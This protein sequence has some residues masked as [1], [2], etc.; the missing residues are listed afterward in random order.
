LPSL[1]ARQIHPKY[2]VPVN[3]IYVTALFSFLLSLIYIGSETAFYAIT[4]LFTVALLQCYMFSIGSIL[5]RRIR[6]P[7]TIPESSFSLGRWGIPI[8]AVALVWCAWS[9][10]SLPCCQSRRPLTDISRQFWSFWPQSTPT[11]VDDFNWSSVI[12]VGVIIVATI[13]YWISGHKNYH[14]PVVLVKKM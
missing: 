3:A 7:E 8:N 6:L 5:W 9:F 4:S 14:G 10:V 11:T 12:F 1:T 13:H 2:L